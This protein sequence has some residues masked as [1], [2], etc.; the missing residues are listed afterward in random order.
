MDTEARRRAKEHIMS[1][2]SGGRRPSGATGTT[3]ATVVLA[4]ARHLDAVLASGLTGP[5][6][7]VFTPGPGDL[8]AGIVPYGGSLSEPG[9]DFAL[10]EDFYLQTQDYASS[11]F[12]SVL[13]PTVLRVFGPS[14]FSAFLADADR[15]FTEG[16][17]PEYLITPA[18]LLADTAALGGPRGNDGPA[19]RLYVDTE[20]RISLSPTGSPLG[21]VGDDLPALLARYEHVNAASEA[22]C[23][24]SL[25]AAVPEEARTAALQV[26]PF[27]GRY[28][29]AVKALRALTAQDIGGL[30]VSGFGHRV[31]P[32][33][34]A[35]AGDD[36][37]GPGLPLVLWN[38]E[39]SYVV[40]GGR[41]FAVDR[42]FAGAVECL[43][44]GPVAEGLTPGHV[45]DQVRAFFTER[46]LSLQTR[47]PVGAR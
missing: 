16:V 47:T 46:G 20:G 22:P 8:A 23:A 7:L 41:V 37:T 35:D 44:A 34:A 28:H 18:V 45:L 4:D 43:L 6:T 19:L 26:R 32:G 38:A 5:G 31:T 39:Q 10:G 9:E 40:A 21:T 30:K 12:M 27:L 25:G 33:L 17:F 11:A 3:V 29:A 14:D 15:A 42:A 13:G 36:L 24:V 2:G 1:W